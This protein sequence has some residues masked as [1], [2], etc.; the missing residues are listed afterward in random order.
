TGELKE[1]AL[2][3]GNKRRH[4]RTTSIAMNSGNLEAADNTINPTILIQVAPAFTKRQLDDVVEDQRVR[5]NVRRN[6]SE[7]PAIERV[8]DHSVQWRIAEDVF[9]CVCD[10][11]SKRVRQS[12]LNAIREPP[13]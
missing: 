9:A 4:S 6:G 8:L 7:R 3:S 1:V 2:S 12:S 11:L 5:R 10:Q 13:C